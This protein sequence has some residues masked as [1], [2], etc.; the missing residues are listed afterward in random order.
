VPNRTHQATCGWATIAFENKQ[1]IDNATAAGTNHYSTH[2]IMSSTQDEGASTDEYGEVPQPPRKKNK[3]ATVPEVPSMLDALQNGMNFTREAANALVAEGICEAKDLII[4]HDVNAL[5]ELMER[6]RYPPVGDGAVVSYMSEKILR[7]CCYG[8]YCTQLMDKPVDNSLLTKEFARRWAL[9][10]K[11]QKACCKDTE[12]RLE[13]HKYG[14]EW[15]EIFEELEYHIRDFYSDVTHVSLA[16]LIR[17]NEFP[18]EISVDS[19]PRDHRF[20]SQ[21]QEL[22]QRCRHWRPV[23]Q[24]NSTELTQ[25]RPEYYDEDNAKLFK[26][27][28]KAFQ[29][30]LIGSAF[31]KRFSYQEDG[32][33]AYL[34]LKKKFLTDFYLHETLRLTQEN[35]LKMQFDAQRGGKKA[36]QQYVNCHRK[37]HAVYD[38]LKQHGCKHTPNDRTRLDHFCLGIKGA[39]DKVFTIKF[40]S[41]QTFENAVFAL[42]VMLFHWN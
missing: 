2:N 37:A 32:R 18:E 25:E 8:L 33:G 35:L 9:Y 12:V 1:F 24:L 13:L 5:Q 36:F 10:Q 14:D 3:I 20:Q 7:D 34:E 11:V 4:F 22:I 39:N 28:T 30:H 19:E 42:S 15:W 27:L 21:K 40:P 23:C 17:E 38:S 31:I 6:L 16:Y 41:N 29:R 26:I